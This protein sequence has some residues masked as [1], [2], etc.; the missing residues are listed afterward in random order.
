VKKLAGLPNDPSQ[1][2]QRRSTRNPAAKA[3]EEAAR[4]LVGGDPD[5]ALHTGLGPVGG[6]QTRRDPT[7][8]QSAKR[9]MAGDAEATDEYEKLTLTLAGCARHPKSS[10][11][12]SSG[13]RPAADMV[14]GCAPFPAACPVA[15]TTEAVDWSPSLTKQAFIWGSDGTPS[16]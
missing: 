13:K 9:L 16:S 3:R 8:W 14:A 7:R 12:G 1:R 15:S 6:C 11:V 2:S 4:G 5:A 10:A